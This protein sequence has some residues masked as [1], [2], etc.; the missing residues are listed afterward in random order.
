M[1]VYVATSWRNIYFDDVVRSLEEDGHEVYD[2][3]RTSGAAFGWSQ[4][5]PEWQG[6]STNE[7]IDALHHPR[8]RAG[9][10]SDMGALA[11]CDALVLVLPCGRSAHLEA[12]WAVGAGK[13]VI[14]YSPEPC[15]A[16]LMYRMCAFVTSR[17]ADVFRALR[18]WEGRH[19][20]NV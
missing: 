2:F 9:F 5:D 13:K 11:C 4:I 20:D 18:V 3:K 1:R 19:K 7:F 6:W 15:E 17:F 10:R 14:V 12:G 8:A 16:E